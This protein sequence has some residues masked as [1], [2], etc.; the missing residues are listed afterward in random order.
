M[1][2]KICIV[3]NK[4]FKPTK[5]I[6]K[7]HKE[8]AKKVK[9]QYIKSWRAKNPEKVKEQ[10]RKWA[11]EHYVKKIEKKKCSECDNTFTGKTTKKTCSK[12]CALKRQV[13]QNKE[14]VKNNP[15]RYRE[16][17]NKAANKYWYKKKH[18]EI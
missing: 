13:R 1:N 7:Y 11:K 15:E 8:C 5:G 10:S 18:G 3:C 17:H 9:Y 2:N 12:A 16:L 6:Q 14:W 4:E